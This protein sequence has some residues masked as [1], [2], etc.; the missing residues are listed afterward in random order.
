MFNFN[1]NNNNN[2]RNNVN[3]GRN[4]NSVSSNNL[5]GFHFGSGN[6]NNNNNNNI[7]GGDGSNITN[8]SSSNNAG[9]FV[10]AN[11]TDEMDVQVDDGYNVNY[12]VAR[13]SPRQG[14]FSPDR[15]DNPPP[16]MDTPITIGGS[17]GHMARVNSQGAEYGTPN[18]WIQLQRAVAARTSA[19]RG[20]GR[21]ATYDVDAQEDALTEAQKRADVLITKYNKPK[22]VEQL[23]SDASKG[24]GDRSLSEDVV[25]AGTILSDSII[26]SM[27]YTE[28]LEAELKNEK[29]KAASLEEL[30]STNESLKLCV[31]VAVGA[32]AVS[33]YS[34][35]YY[36]RKLIDDAGGIGFDAQ[37]PGT[38]RE[39]AEK[40]RI[41][42]NISTAAEVLEMKHNGQRSKKTLEEILHKIDHFKA[43]PQFRQFIQGLK[44]QSINYLGQRT[45]VLPGAFPTHR[46]ACSS[47][48]SFKYLRLMVVLYLQCPGFEDALL[49]DHLNDK[50]KNV[51]AQF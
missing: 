14:Y 25:H 26:A 43:H 45:R 15:V 46:I 50:E 33:E 40:A 42:L 19:G 12:A 29:K 23:L 1:R 3:N 48:N 20:V 2:N 41:A 16:P 47:R 5:G 36:V 31:G 9:G 8:S 38:L 51:A 32:S 35:K 39:V 21:R 7:G 10:F 4:L 37:N 34:S 30:F 24:I 17:H 27:E 22:V 49:N 6:D 18:P 44:D 28:L 13:S 11:D